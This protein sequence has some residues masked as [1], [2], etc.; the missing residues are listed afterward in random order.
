MS[1]GN[2]T[3]NDVVFSVSLAKL[4][5][6]LQIGVYI[7]YIILLGKKQITYYDLIILNR[8]TTNNFTIPVKLYDYCDHCQMKANNKKI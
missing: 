3:K 7:H 2:K 4:N 1:D 8:V 5:G 6:R